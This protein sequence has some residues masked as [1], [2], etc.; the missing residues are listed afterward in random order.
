MLDRRAFMGSGVSGMA[1]FAGALSCFSV[2]DPRRPKGQ[3]ETS[4]YRSCAFRWT[5]FGLAAIP[6]E[7]ALLGDFVIFTEMRAD[8]PVGDLDLF[9][10]MPAPPGH[11]D[12]PVLHALG[13]YSTMPEARVA[14]DAHVQQMAENFAK[15]G[16]LR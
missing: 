14:I 5:G 10:I 16:G 7:Q 15:H 1:G 3:L 13:R 11:P 12:R 2:Q 9:A 4:D 8:R 6:L